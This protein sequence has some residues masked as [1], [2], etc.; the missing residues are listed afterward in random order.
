MIVNALLS[1]R[2]IFLF[3]PEIRIRKERKIRSFSLTLTI[4]SEGSL[5]RDEV[6][7]EIPLIAYDALLR[8]VIGATINK[9]R[10]RVCLYDNYVAEVDI[11]VGNLAPLMIVEVEFN[12]EKEAGTFI[13]PDWFGKE[14]T[15]DS[16]YK[17]KN[18]AKC[19][20]PLLY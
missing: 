13:V 9:R 16:R 2:D 7:V 14:V 3:L 11:Y 1:I 15:D 6:N 12:S 5:V 20:L 10:Y 4:K 8:N 18:L 17:N 19:G